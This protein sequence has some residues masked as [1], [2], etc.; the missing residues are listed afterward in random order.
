MYVLA[1]ADTFSGGEGLSCDLQ[2]AGRATV[3]GEATGGGAN[4]HYPYRV[5]AH[6]MSGVPSGY[7]INP[8]SGARDRG[9]R[10]ARAR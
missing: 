5:T 9:R 3:V 1:S 2:Q 4:F 10:P 8:V 7:P 6:R